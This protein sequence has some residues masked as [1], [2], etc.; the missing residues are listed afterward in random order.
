MTTMRRNILRRFGLLAALAA[1]RPAQAGPILDWLRERR[2][3][4]SDL[5]DDGTS[6]GPILGRQYAPPPDI[7]VQ[8]DVAYGN[9]PAQRL[10]VYRRPG[11]KDGPVMVMVHGGGCRRGDKAGRSM[12]KNKVQHW[13]GKGWVFVSLCLTPTRSNR[14]GTWAGHWPLCRVARGSGAATR[15]GWC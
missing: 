6:D 10:D 1:A 7:D 9:D 2:A 5:D 8:R 14:A 12:V 11:A 3:E 4:R 15:P 13:V